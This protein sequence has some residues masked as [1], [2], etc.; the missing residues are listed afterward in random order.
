MEKMRDG[1]DNVLRIPT[2]DKSVNGFNFAFI[3]GGCCFS[4]TS[5]I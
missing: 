4:D 3:Y 2:H 1:R 5:L